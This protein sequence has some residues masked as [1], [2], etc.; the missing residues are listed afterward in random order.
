MNLAMPAPIN[1]KGFGSE[2]NDLTQWYQ[3]QLSDKQATTEPT[4]LD[5]A[6]KQLDQDRAVRE[7]KIK[8]KYSIKESFERERM[9]LSDEFSRAMEEF[10]ARKTGATK[11][12]MAELEIEE[13]SAREMVNAEHQ[14]VEQALVKEYQDRYEALQTKY[15]IPRG[16]LLTPKRHDNTQMAVM[17]SIFDDWWRRIQDL[18][19]RYSN[20]AVEQTNHLMRNPSN[21]HREIA[22]LDRDLEAKERAGKITSDLEEGIVSVLTSP[23]RIPSWFWGIYTKWMEKRFGWLRDR[24]WKSRVQKEDPDANIDTYIFNIGTSNET[25]K[26]DY[27]ALLYALLTLSFLIIFVGMSKIPIVASL[28]KYLY[29]QVVAVLALYDLAWLAF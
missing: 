3:E 1:L 4:E 28:I 23:L 24:W 11:A 5:A 19:T 20:D 15:G 12:R 17:E 6:L 22:N 18:F 9:S 8:S 7:I 14:E 13:I 16:D 21:I 29:S 10:Q 26:E 27:T 25:S 2:M